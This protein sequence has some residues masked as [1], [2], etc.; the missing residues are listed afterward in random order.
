M[1]VS[2]HYTAFSQ[3]IA[4]YNPS[5]RQNCIFQVMNELKLIPDLHYLLVFFLINEMR[6]HKNKQDKYMYMKKNACRTYARA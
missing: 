2:I 4:F 1:F 5:F 6:A 3:S